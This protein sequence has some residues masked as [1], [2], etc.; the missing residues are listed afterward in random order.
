MSLR[1]CVYYRRFR[2]HISPAESAL[3][4]AC[5]CKH[6]YRVISYEYKLQSNSIRGI[7]EFSKCT[8]VQKIFSQMRTKKFELN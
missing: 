1:L 5:L 8:S 4:V 6:L 7:L 2:L 3:I